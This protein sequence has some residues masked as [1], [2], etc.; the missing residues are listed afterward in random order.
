M[1]IFY[2]N[3]DPIVCANEHCTIHVNKMI[4]EYAQMLST[5]YR[6]IDPCDVRY[7]EIG[8]Y[9]VTHENHPCTK[10]V[11]ESS[12]NYTW[13]FR[14]FEELLEIYYENK[15]KDHATY[16]LKNELSYEP[17]GLVS[18]G[19]SEP[20]KVMPDEYV[21]GDVIQSYRNFLNSKFINWTTRTD[22]RRMTVNWFGNIPEWVS[23]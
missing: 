10:W 18:R 16:K 17:V 22:K 14:V 1:N 4:I 23:L 11:R 20:P 7:N 8:L 6:L 9:K 2:T 3:S 5:T 21:T 13:L 19:F 12:E 15:G